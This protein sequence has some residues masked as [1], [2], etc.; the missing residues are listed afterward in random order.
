MT[1][2]DVEKISERMLWLMPETLYCGRHRHQRKWRW[3]RTHPKLPPSHKQQGPDHEGLT[4]RVLRINNRN[5]YLF[6]NT[7]VE[8][9]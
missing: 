9:E 3:Y 4:A 1:I 5:F 6:V 8:P 2:E 7:Q